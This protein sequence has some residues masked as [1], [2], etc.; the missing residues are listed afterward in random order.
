VLAE[1]LVPVVA[2]NL[3]WLPVLYFPLRRLAGRI[4]PPR[5]GW[6]R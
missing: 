3:L 4:G 1:D 5:M 6:E 2:L